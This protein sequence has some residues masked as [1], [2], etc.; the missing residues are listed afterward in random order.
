MQ[1]DIAKGKDSFSE[2]A[3]VVVVFFLAFPEPCHLPL[4]GPFIP[5][6]SIQWPLN[7]RQ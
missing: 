1:N 6:Q 7:G 5:T 4:I 3:N 2:S